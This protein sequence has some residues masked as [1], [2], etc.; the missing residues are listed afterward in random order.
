[1]GHET[2]FCYA[3]SIQGFGYGDV[4]HQFEKLCLKIILLT[5]A[6]RH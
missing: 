4:V 5:F 1:M 6:T 2:H 3:K